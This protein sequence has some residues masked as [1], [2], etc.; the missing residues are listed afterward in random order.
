MIC[1][2]SIVERGVASSGSRDIRMSWVGHV[3]LACLGWCVCVVGH[4]ARHI[5][6][7][8]PSEVEVGNSE[9]VAAHDA[10]TVSSLW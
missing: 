8:A 5:V 2:T 4:V 7:N 10:I 1:V 3:T 6:V 9:V